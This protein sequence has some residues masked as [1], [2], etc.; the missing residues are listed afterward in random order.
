MSNLNNNVTAFNKYVEIQLRMLEARSKTTLDLLNLLIEA[1]LSVPDDKRDAHDDGISLLVPERLM[2]LAKTKYKTLV[3]QAKWLSPSEHE[4]KRVAL[5]AK[6]EKVERVNKQLQG[7]L[8]GLYK[9]KGTDERS[10]DKSKPK[11]KENIKG[12]K[13]S[14]K[15]A[16]KEKP[17]K[18][19]N[20]KTKTFN[21]KLYHW[22]KF[23]KPWMVHQE[24]ECSLNPDRT[25]L[26]E[27]EANT[28]GAAALLEAMLSVLKQG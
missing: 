1:Y 2:V 20:P 14:N 4:Q 26:K 28:T 5:T 18:E 8:K 11:A 12:K 9:Q 15:W 7:K 24:S 3:E 16:W 10:K 25:D 22:C 13:Q 17:P 23:H 19:G 27:D 6:L 21:D